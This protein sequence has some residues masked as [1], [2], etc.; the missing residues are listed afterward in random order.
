MNP[1]G[2]CTCA[3]YS[4]HIKTALEKGSLKIEWLNSDEAARYLKLPIKS[5]MNLTSRGA[6]P[7]YKLGRLNKYRRDELD[8]ILLQNKRGQNGN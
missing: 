8:Y 3:T 6:I 5:L 2:K 4:H 7:Y 1:L